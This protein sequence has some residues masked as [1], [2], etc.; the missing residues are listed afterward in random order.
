[1]LLYAAKEAL[2][3]KMA[4]LFVDK[5]VEKVV[6]KAAGDAM[7]DGLEKGIESAS[8]KKAATSSGLVTGGLIALA[9]YNGIYKSQQAAKIADLITDKY[10]N[11]VLSDMAEAGASKRE[12][13]ARQKDIEY[14]QERWAGLS[15]KIQMIRDE[16]NGGKDLELPSK[17]LESYKSAETSLDG[18]AEKAGKLKTNI[19]QIYD[20][21]A[22][23]SLSNMQKDAEK[24]SNSIGICDTKAATAV[25]NMQNSC[26]ALKSTT[27]NLAISVEKDTG[28]ISSSVGIADTKA[29]EALKNMQKNINTVT[30]KPLSDDISKNTAESTNTIHIFD[31]KAEQSFKEMQKVATASVQSIDKDTKTSMDNTKKTIDESMGG[32]VNIVIES[33]GEM[34][35]SAA[36]CAENMTKSFNGVKNALSE[37]EWTTDG[38]AKGLT[39]TFE[40]AKAGVKR[41]WNSIADTLNGD[42]QIGG[43]S[44]PIHLPKFANGGFVEDGIFTMN[45]NEIAG[46]FNNGKTVVAN[47]EQITD[48][49]AQAVF[50]AMVSANAGNSGEHYINNTIYIDDV[51]VARAVT[52]GQNKLSRRFSPTT[53]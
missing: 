37:D 6:E 39:N 45:H 4:S 42:H 20:S 12:I 24:A 13:E 1:M 10:K 8:V 44:F 5:A 23:E 19:S 2:K 32:A 35:S 18:I 16:W 9:I 40:A 17:T 43:G 53:V 11:R 25:K 27:G 50:N 29:A 33:A 52:K 49:I 48:G 14:L 22:A 3:K 31:T 15:G 51:A 7:A 41:I 26:D 47:N 38:V 36:E 28:S 21:K 34:K 30:F 46:R